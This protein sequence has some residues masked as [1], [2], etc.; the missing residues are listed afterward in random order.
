MADQETTKL[1]DLADA[2]GEGGAVM[3]HRHCQSPRSMPRAG[4]M[5][6]AAARTPSP[7]CGSSRALDGSRSMAASSKPISPGRCCAWCCSSRSSRRAHEPVRCGVHGHRRRTVRPGGCG[8][9]RLARAL[10]RYEPALAACSRKGGFLTRDSRVV[11]R[12]K[13][14]KAKARRSFQFSK[15]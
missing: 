15:R 1:E 7:G 14:G 12:K 2:L 11:E 6:P 5:Q 13:Y 8:A 10:T 3:P 9:P 4:P